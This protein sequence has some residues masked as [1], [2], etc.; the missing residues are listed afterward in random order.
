M[1]ESPTTPEIHEVA[2]PGTDV[3][4]RLTRVRL[5][6]VPAGALITRRSL[7]QFSDELVGADAYDLVMGLALRSTRSLD[8][9]LADSRVWQ[10]EI[11]KGG[12]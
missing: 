2:L 9:L 1:A 6:D 8:P 10:V 5:G 12:A 7:H 4:C 11:Q 3:T